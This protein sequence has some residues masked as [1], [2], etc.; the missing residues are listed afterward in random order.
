MKEFDF[1]DPYLLQK[2][3]ENEKALGLLGKRL[4]Y[5]DNLE[6]FPR[7]EM[8]I[9]SILAGNMF[10]WGAREVA[11]L[12]E[13]TDFGFHEARSK[14]QARP[15]LVDGLDKWIDRLK[16]PPHKCAAIFVDNS[17]IDIVLGILPFARELLERGTKVILCANSA[18]ALNDVTHS[19]LVMLLKQAA[20]VCGVIRSALNAGTLIPMETAQAGPCLDL[21]R[22]N[23]DLA[24][25]MSSQGVDLI[26]LE[27]MGRAL[28]TNLEALFTC[29]C[30]KIAV[31]KNRWLATRLGGDMFSVLCKY[32]CPNEVKEDRKQQGLNAVK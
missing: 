30:L 29:E 4:E 20:A 21:S 18:P 13:N 17:G 12:M 1:P 6:W 11:D 32:E 3:M 27:G 24:N 28:H 2:Q 26:V 8:L 10:D 9:T 5:L 31:I 16:G 22:L 23:L 7:Q 25:A 14:I 15:W 19:E